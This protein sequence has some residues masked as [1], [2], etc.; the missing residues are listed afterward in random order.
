MMKHL[1]SI[2]AILFVTTI[3]CNNNENSSN[4]SIDNTIKTTV[5]NN[6]MIGSWQ[7]SDMDFDFK[8]NM[9]LPGIAEMINKQLNNQLKSAVSDFK[10]TYNT[11]GTFEVN[12][13]KSNTKGKYSIE[14]GELV[15]SN[16]SNGE[17]LLNYANA[18]II[19]DELTLQITAE[20]FYKMLASLQGME[21]NIEQFKKIMTINKLTYKFKKV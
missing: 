3:S 6:E 7:F 15:H 4:N 5:S 16:L 1:F 8:L 18:Q 9:E 20:Q 14:N 19:G 2:I 10:I 12:G 21:E 11:D 13:S 17:T